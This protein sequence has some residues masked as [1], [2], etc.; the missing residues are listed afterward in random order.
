[1]SGFRHGLVFFYFNLDKVIDK[2]PCTMAFLTF[3]SC[4]FVN[5]GNSSDQRFAIAEQIFSVS[6]LTWRHFKGKKYTRVQV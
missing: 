4:L 5:E 1:M 2:W 6:P 3:T